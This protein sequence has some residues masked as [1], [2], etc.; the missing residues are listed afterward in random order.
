MCTHTFGLGE[1]DLAINATAGR[2]V[3]GAVHVIVDP[4]LV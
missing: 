4:W 2:K 3:T 1:V